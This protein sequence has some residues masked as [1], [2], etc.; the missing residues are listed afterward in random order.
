M[1]QDTKTEEKIIIAAKKVF[2][3]KGMAGARMQEIANE[4]GINKSLLHY[5]FRSKEK[6][7][8]AIF[9]ETFRKFLPRIDML[10]SS[11]KSIEE[12]LKEFVKEYLDLLKKNPHIPQFILHELSSNPEKLVDMMKMSGIREI[13]PIGQ[14]EKMLNDSK[15]KNVNVRHLFI[16]LIS[17]CIFPFV[18]RPILEHVVMSQEEFDFDKLIEERKKEIPKFIINSIVK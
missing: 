8:E 11:E 18:A 14:L 5:Y 6:L 1:E 9:E 10:L 15:I 7:F 17:M 4:A 12:K 3:Q 16:N 13:N 2:I